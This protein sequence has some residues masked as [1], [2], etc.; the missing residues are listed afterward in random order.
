[1]LQG[2]RLILLQAISKMR[3][4]GFQVEPVGP[5]RPFSRLKDVKFDRIPFSNGLNGL[6]RQTGQPKTLTH[7]F[8]MVCSRMTCA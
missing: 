5:L 4:Y 6:N 3:L 7:M 1:M 2:H 8:K